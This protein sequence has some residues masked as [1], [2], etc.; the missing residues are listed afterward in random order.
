MVRGVPWTHSAIV[1]LIRDADEDGDGKL[2]FKEVSKIC[3]Y[4]VLGII[5]YFS[6]NFT[7]LQ[8]NLRFQRIFSI[9]FYRTNYDDA[10]PLLRIMHLFNDSNCDLFL[11]LLQAIVVYICM[12]K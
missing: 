9:S 5:K 7:I 8:A 10:V 2:S 3:N 12:Y 11:G 1:R 6:N 4:Y